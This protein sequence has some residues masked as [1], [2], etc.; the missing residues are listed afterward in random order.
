MSRFWLQIRPQTL[1]LVFAALMIGVFVKS[2]FLEDR[3]VL[4]AGE[5]KPSDQVL[6]A[7]EIL[8]RTPTGSRL[9][10]EAHQ[11]FGKH[12]GDWI[13][14]GRVSKTD[15]LLVRKFNSTTGEEKR[16]RRVVIYIDF[17]QS[18]EFIAL[19]LAHE[20]VH[21]LSKPTWDPYDPHLTP[22]RYIRF[23]IEGPGGEIDALTT[24]CKVASE[25]GQVFPRCESYRAFSKNDRIRE[26][27]K[28]DFYRVG[29]WKESLL[30]KLRKESQSFPDLSSKEPKL[31]SATGSSPYPAA[32]LEEYEMLTEAACRNSVKLAKSL[33]RKPTEE[34]LEFIDLRCSRFSSS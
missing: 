16:E 11:V 7:I 10:R 12:L 1:V 21:A 15:S 33:T 32:L 24:E 17:N 5:I 28:K 9:I 34:I 30:K 13:Q 8:E 2:Y 20:L 4:R 31:F 23:A 27:V 25:M 29:K 6:R 26:Q 22:G 14:P 19:D 3:E 18:D